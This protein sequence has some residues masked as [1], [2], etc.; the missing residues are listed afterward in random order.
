MRLNRPR[1]TYQWPRFSEYN[2]YETENIQ[3][4]EIPQEPERCPP[5][6]IYSSW[7]N[8]CILADAPKQEFYPAGHLYKGF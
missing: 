8:G 1:P 6:Q 2:T 3:V 4:P 5:G 7:S